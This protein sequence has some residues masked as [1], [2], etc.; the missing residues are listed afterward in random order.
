MKKNT[1]L[2]ILCRPECAAAYLMNENI[3]IPLNLNVITY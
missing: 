3:T 2:W 1:W